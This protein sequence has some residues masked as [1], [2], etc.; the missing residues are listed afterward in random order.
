MP[1]DAATDPVVVASVTFSKETHMNTMRDAHREAWEWA[2]R[3]GLP[4]RLL[5]VGRKR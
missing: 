1:A 3:A 4:N 2:P 5:L